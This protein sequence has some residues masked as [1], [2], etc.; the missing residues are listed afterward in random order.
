MKKGLNI[1]L[2]THN[3]ASTSRAHVFELNQAKQL[4]CFK[5]AA[6]FTHR[7]NTFNSV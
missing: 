1:L 4:H 5:T 7:L 2:E 3:T 6:H